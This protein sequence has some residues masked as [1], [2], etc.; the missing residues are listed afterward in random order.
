MWL[1]LFLQSLN[2]KDMKAAGLK[3]TAED[4]YSVNKGSMKDALMIFGGGCTASVISDKGLVLTNH[5]C[6]YDAIQEASTIEKNYLK[7]G[8]WAANN[9][10]E[11]PSAGL[12][13]FVVH[14]MPVTGPSSSASST[15]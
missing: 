12:S 5:H 2:E 14:P 15:A 13:V 6:G 10:A 11:I 7:N 1:L 4:I 9:A 3:I 8:F